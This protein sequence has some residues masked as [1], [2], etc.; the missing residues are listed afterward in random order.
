MFPDAIW[1]SLGLWSY[2]GLLDGRKL[3]W[4][5]AFLGSR[6]RGEAPGLALLDPGSLQATPSQWSPAH[7]S[8]PLPTTPSRL[9]LGLSSERR[10]GGDTDSAPV[11]RSREGKQLGQGHPATGSHSQAP[12]KQL[13]SA[14][15]VPGPFI[16]GGMES[17]QQPW[18]HPH[19][20][21]EETEA[22]REPATPP[23]S[24]ARMPT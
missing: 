7:D 18:E 3:F 2:L 10:W 12:S 13:L 15:C 5:K 19:C 23:S 4:P 22:Q 6:E 1:A 20:A 24:I 21:E 9:T 16:C 17:P 14:Y 11:S 8:Q